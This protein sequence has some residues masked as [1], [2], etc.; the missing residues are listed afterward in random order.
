MQKKVFIVSAICLLFFA[1]LAVAS[2]IYINANIE[3]ITRRHLGADIQFEDVE[4]NLTPLPA[5]VFSQLKI[6]KGT[7]RITIPSLVL[8]PDLLALLTGN[9]V[10]RKA[11]VDEPLI[12]SEKVSE[13]TP[14]EKGIS[15]ESPPAPAS[16]F[17]TAAIPVGMI[18]EIMV[19]GGKL[20]LNSKDQKMPPVSFAVAVDK[21]EKKDQAISVQV[22]DF[23]VDEI[24]LSFAGNVAITSF[25]PLGLKIDASKAAINPAALK[26]FLVKF[27]FL[28][29]ALGNQIPKIDQ[30]SAGGLKLNIDPESGELNLVSK[31][32]SFGQNQLQDV[33]VNLSKKKGYTLKCGKVLMDVGTVQGWVNENP[34]GKEALEQLFLK[35]R[36]KD[37]KA[38]G[39]IE[40][41]AIDLKG[42]GENGSQISGAMDLKTEG[43]KIRLVAENGKEQN[44]TISRLET[45][46]TL[47]DGKPSLQISNLQ[48]ASSRGG[49]GLLKGTLEIPVELKK[50]RF[51]ATLDS[52]QVFDTAVNLKAVKNS[53]EKLSFD[54]D[55]SGPSLTLLAK[56]QLQTPGREKADFWIRMTECRI[57]RGSKGKKEIVGNQNHFP[58]KKWELSAGKAPA[59][60]NFDFTVIK[61]RTLTGEASVKRFQYNDL[62]QVNDVHLLLTCANNRAVVRGSMG[63]CQVDLFVNAVFMSPDQLVA[64]VEGK[65]AN[66]NLTPFMACF[67]RELP[68][69]LSGRLSLMTSLFVQG[70]DTETLLDSAHGEVT[71][72]LRKCTVRKVSSLDYR[73]DFL[74][75]MLNAAGITSLRDD[76]INFKKGLAKAEITKGRI[77]LDR[78]SLTGPLLDV[79]GKGEFTTKEKQLKL[80]GQ[81]RTALGIT[82]DFKID[83]NFQRKK[84]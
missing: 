68:L 71:V 52:F 53:G 14:Q 76:A 1:A 61:G 65:G 82:N 26:D 39:K 79:W 38:T 31:T 51:E 40:L 8:Y 11:V 69:F 66:M 2:G 72:T 42:G 44:F 73:L 23:T 83:R 63:I 7:N 74:V 32:L 21:I 45:R 77:I 57:S 56:G 64:Q 70:Q 46:I 22:K 62:P 4:F 13:S 27:E 6:K 16:P 15:S 33:S 60:G 25:S 81:V 29:A 59:T 78:F 84:T 19:R 10:M 35:A 9:V 50:A 48:L 3:D 43:L 24:G 75:D 67:S 36:L 34:K 20:V 54:M 41:S 17:T 80:A 18:N 12:L 37:L 28:D 49:T 47:E 58:D 30:V 5:V 55:V